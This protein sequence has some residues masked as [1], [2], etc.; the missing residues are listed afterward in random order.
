MCRRHRQQ[1]IVAGLRCERSEDG[2]DGGRA[3]FDVHHLVTD[4]VA[5]QRRLRRRH[6]VRD[7]HV[8]V[9]ED[10]AP[11]GDDIGVRPHLLGGEQLVK[12]QVPRLERV[13]RGGRLVRQLPHGGVDDRG[14]DVPVVQQRRVG[15]EALLT[16]QF[17]VVEVAV[18]VAVLSV[19]L[20]RDDAELSV[21]RHGGGSAPRRFLRPIEAVT[22]RY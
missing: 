6:H 3:G 9:A 11:P 12:L 16:H 15:R 18:L 8:G 13:V 5:V 4:D 17:L 1:H 14:R 22:P 19:T 7:A 2:F 21:E 20:R 10:Q